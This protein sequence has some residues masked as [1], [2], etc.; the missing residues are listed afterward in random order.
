MKKTSIAILG[1][2]LLSAFIRPALAFTEGA[3]KA[4]EEK[5]CKGVPIIGGKLKE[6]MEKHMEQLSDACKANI[7]EMAIKKK[8]KSAG[9]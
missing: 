2:F 6:C 8:E 1:L 4:D 3:C 9:N 7:L 5:Y